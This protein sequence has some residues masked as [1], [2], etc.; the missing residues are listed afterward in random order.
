MPTISSETSEFSGLFH[1]FR[2]GYYE[3][4][5]NFFVTELQ[6]DKHKKS[7]ALLEKTYLIIE[8]EMT[9]RNFLKKRIATHST[10]ISQEYQLE[11]IVM[12]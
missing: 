3:L 7:F 9:V 4:A 2:Q 10:H 6:R 11:K 5:W 1:F 12:F 8:T